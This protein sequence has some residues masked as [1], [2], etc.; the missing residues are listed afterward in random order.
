MLE[1]SRELCP[2]PGAQ[3]AGSRGRARPGGGSSG[4]VAQARLRGE[5]FSGGS[6]PARRRPSQVGLAKVTQRLSPHAWP[7]THPRAAALQTLA[8]ETVPET[9]R[10]CAPDQGPIPGRAG[11]VRPASPPAPARAGWLYRGAR[12]RLAGPS[13]ARARSRGN[14]AGYGAPQRPNRCVTSRRHPG[15]GRGSPGTPW[16]PSSTVLRSFPTFLLKNPLSPPP[17]HSLSS[18]NPNLSQR[19]SPPVSPL[20]PPLSGSPSVNLHTF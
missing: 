14:G 17:I 12:L 7:S 5:N 10:R 9:R 16:R 13:P 18:R 19:Y 11:E 3:A 8:A 6:S 1:G 15:S 4:P 2:V 20:S